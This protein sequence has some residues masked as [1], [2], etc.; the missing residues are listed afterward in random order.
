MPVYVYEVLNE[1]GSAAATVEVRQGIHDPPLQRDPVSG[2]PVRRIVVGV[3]VGLRHTS[4]QDRRSLS[5]ENLERHGFTR[6]ERDGC[7]GYVR[8]A[9]HEGPA[10]VRP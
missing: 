6:Y 3:T 7:G 2:R 8:T 9:G 5:R 10:Q 4:A 1:D